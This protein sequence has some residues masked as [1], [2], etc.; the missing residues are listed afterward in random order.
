MPSVN[1]L[2][3][4]KTT[5][6]SENA[7]VNTHTYNIS[8]QSKLEMETKCENCFEHLLN[9]NNTNNFR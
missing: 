7:Q 1:I 2:I 3:G 6:K 4:F 8:V 5:C 9:Q